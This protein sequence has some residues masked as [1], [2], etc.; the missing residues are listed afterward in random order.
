MSL[1]NDLTVRHRRGLVDFTFCHVQAAKMSQR[2]N[3]WSTNTLTFMPESRRN[4]ETLSNVHQKAWKLHVAGAKRQ[5]S[6]YCCCEKKKEKKKLLK[7]EKNVRQSPRSGEALSL[8]CRSRTWTSRQSTDW[9]FL[10]NPPP[11]EKLPHFFSVSPPISAL[12]NSFTKG[13][14][15]KQL[16]F[17]DRFR[18]KNK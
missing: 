1:V 15:N 13:C 8:L 2:L 5:L 17:W 4:T 18:G 6:D 14:F 9:R 16:F 7:Q 10:K 3:S 11:K 12:G